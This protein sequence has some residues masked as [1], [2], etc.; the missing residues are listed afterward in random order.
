MTDDGNDVKT[1]QV[2][3]S[4][5]HSEDAQL[6]VLNGD[7]ISGDVIQTSDPDHYVHYIHRVV[8]PLVDEDHLWAST[9]GNHDS[10]PNLDP[11]MDI[12]SLEKQYSTSL[13]QSYISGPEAGITNYYLPVYPHGNSDGPPALV[14]WFFDS[15]GGYRASN[16]DTEAS[17]GLRGDWVHESVCLFHSIYKSIQAD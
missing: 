5:L 7:L 16:R 10:N 4:V 9:Y 8:A 17:Q 14:L 3:R 11:L 1:Q 6:V 2:I 15:R 13:T 12:Y